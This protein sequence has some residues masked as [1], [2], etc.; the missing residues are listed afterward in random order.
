MRRLSVAVILVFCAL[1]LV[2]CGKRYVGQ[3]IGY[4][5]D[6]WC[7]YHSGYYPAFGEGKQCILN[8]PHMVFDFIIKK[9][10]AEQDYVIE[11]FI[12]FSQGNIKSFDRLMDGPSRFFMLVGR[13]NR[14][15]DNVSFRPRT[16]FGDIQK[17]IPFRIEYHSDEGFDKVTFGYAISVSG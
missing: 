1:V 17:R 5:A 10:E 15:I 9:G 7:D 13:G 8:T 14:V 16:I 12:D 11:G 4:P 6:E 3:E 2:S